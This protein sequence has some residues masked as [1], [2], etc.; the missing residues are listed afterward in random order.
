MTIREILADLKSDR[1]KKVILDSDTYNETDDQYALAY[2]YLSEKMDLIA[3]HA[4]PFMSLT[5]EDVHAA[6]NFK[7]DIEQYAQGMELSYQEIHNILKLTDPNYTT[8]VFRGSKE[9]ITDT[10]TYVDSPACDNLIKMVHESDEIVYVLA[11]GAITN[12]ASALLKD[13]SIKDNMVVIW[14]GCDQLDFPKHIEFNMVQDVAAG[15]VLI[16]SGV[17]LLLCPARY[18]TIALRADI[19]LIR[20]LK[21]HSALCDYLSGI[22]E[23]CYIDEGSPADWT[24]VIW[25][26]AAPAIVECPECADI[27]IIPAPVLTD[28]LHFAFDSTRHEIMYLKKLDRDLVYEKA[29]AV[30]K[31]AK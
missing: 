12:V 14:L 4:A 21:G 20:D 25:D 9:R 11:I 31:T 5:F 6:P 3:A 2:C 26:I 8:P 27:D 16:N 29:W 19:D 28:D 17:P 23:Q 7:A 30:L 10:R 24:R 13:P 22:I 18:V 1:K 15:Q